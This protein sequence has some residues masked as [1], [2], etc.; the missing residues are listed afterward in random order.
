MSLSTI[1][2]ARQ[3]LMNEAATLLTRTRLILC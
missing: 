1:A 2:A 3:K